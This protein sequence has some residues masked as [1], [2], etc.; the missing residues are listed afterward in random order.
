MGE[1]RK[2]PGGKGQPGEMGDGGPRQAAEVQAKQERSKRK[3][4]KNVVEV[5]PPPAEPEVKKVEEAAPVAVAKPAVSLAEGTLHKPTPKPGDKVVKPSK[6][7]KA[8]VKA[9]PWD[10]KGTRSAPPS[11]P[12]RNRE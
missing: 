10:E 7:P 8:E 5:E 2:E 1:G 3:T 6:K 9:S 12:A 4:T 11:K